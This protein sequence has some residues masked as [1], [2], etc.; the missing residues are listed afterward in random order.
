[1]PF[2]AITVASDPGSKAD[3]DSAFV[4]A[5]G[6]DTTNATAAAAAQTTADAAATA[7]SQTALKAAFSTFFTLAQPILAKAAAPNG[8]V[9]PTASEISAACQVLIDAL[10]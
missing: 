8:T 5:V 3:I 4:T 7:A 2:A 10:A 6:Y 1:M 9:S